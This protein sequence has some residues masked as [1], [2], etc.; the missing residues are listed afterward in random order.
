MLFNL[1]FQHLLEETNSW[2]VHFKQKLTESNYSG[3]WTLGHIKYANDQY[4]A[5]VNSCFAG[6][7]MSLELSLLV[8]IHVYL[9]LIITVQ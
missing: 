4:M 2:V 7:E 5:V 3:G 9:L 6:G 1:A 8:S